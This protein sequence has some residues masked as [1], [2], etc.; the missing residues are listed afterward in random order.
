[1][2]YKLL[3]SIGFLVAYFHII[4]GLLGSFSNTLAIFQSKWLFGVTLLPD[5]ATMTFSKYVSAYAVAFGLTVLVATKRPK[6][7][8]PILIISAGLFY[9]RA[10]QSLLF[11]Q[12]M[13][14]G[15]HI[16]QF[17]FYCVVLAKIFLGT[18]LIIFAN[19]S[20]TQNQYVDKR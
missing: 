10:L 4:F 1:M 8:Y 12:E 17:S 11:H 19:S 7:M 9:L 16:Q 5:P 18:S 13:V 20:R 15:F 14:Q 3:R 6:E 2:K